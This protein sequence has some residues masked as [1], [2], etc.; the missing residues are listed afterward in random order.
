MPGSWKGITTVKVDG[1]DVPWTSANELASELER[2]NAVF[3]GTFN[4]KILKDKA[5]TAQIDSLAKLQA[6]QAKNAEPNAELKSQIDKGIVGLAPAVLKLSQDPQAIKIGQRLFLQNCSVCHGSQARG[7][8][9]Y[10]NLTDNDW[11][12][13]GSPD[14]ILLTLHHGRVGG[15]PAWKAQIGEDGVRAASEYVLSLSPGKG[16]KDNGQLNQT[17][18]NQGKAIYDTNCAVCHGKDGKGNYDVGAVNLTDDIW[19]YGGDRETVRTTLRNGR[20]GVMP[21]WDT[22]LGNE[23]IMLLAAYVYSLSDH[24]QD[25]SVMTPTTVVNKERGAASTPVETANAVKSAVASAV[26]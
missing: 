14:K 4:D 9:G 18:V 3:T 2:N 11:I 16:S 17:L 19:L 22:K 24:K 10:P 5:V 25:G 6:Q 7:A 20:A 15:M 8:P 13:G 12:Y 23:R 21:H 1:Q 26:K